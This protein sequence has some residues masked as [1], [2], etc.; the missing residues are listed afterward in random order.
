MSQTEAIL[1]CVMK[2]EREVQLDERV[3]RVADLVAIVLLVRCQVE[4]GAGLCGV[5]ACCLDG[6]VEGILP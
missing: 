4:E 3:H 6:G 1:V 5:D 2:V